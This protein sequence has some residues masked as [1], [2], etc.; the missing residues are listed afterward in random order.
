MALIVALTLSGCASDRKPV[1]PAKGTF[2]YK[3]KPAHK[4]VVWL[5]PRDSNTPG[6]PRPSGTVD[7]NGVFVLSTHQPGDGAAA[8]FYRMTVSWYKRGTRG[9]D[10]GPSLLP[11]HYQDPKTS[12]LPVIEIK[13]EPNEIPPIDLKR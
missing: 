13:A 6:E 10:L 11:I 7:E 8:G 4:A 9:D 3:G 1:Y 12:D 5:H 2:L